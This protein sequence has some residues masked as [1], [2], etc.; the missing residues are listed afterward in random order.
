[1]NYGESGSENIDCRKNNWYYIYIAFISTNLKEI[2][3]GNFKL[4]YFLIFI[5]E[6]ILLLGRVE[7]F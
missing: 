1:M 6:K 5:N 3:K 4:D 2:R 7:G